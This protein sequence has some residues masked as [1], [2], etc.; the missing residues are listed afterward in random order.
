[1]GQR[2]VRAVYNRVGLVPGTGAGRTLEGGCIYPRGVR[3][4][5]DV[6]PPLCSYKVVDLLL[7][8]PQNSSR[9]RP[10]LGAIETTAFQYDCGS[11]WYSVYS[12]RITDWTLGQRRTGKRLLYFYVQAIFAIIYI[13]GHLV[14]VSL[15]C[16]QSCLV[17]S[18]R[19]DTLLV[20]ARANRDRDDCR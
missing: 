14:C 7:L 11:L 10:I 17:L 3:G 8:L 1:M 12:S 16:Y 18:R 9:S 15:V 5:T 19:T 20:L 4:E 6:P 13:T 2:H